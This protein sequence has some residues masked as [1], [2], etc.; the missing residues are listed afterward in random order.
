MSDWS[1]RY[2]PT[3]LQGHNF[4][5]KTGSTNVTG[6]DFMLRFMSTCPQLVV[7]MGGVQ[8]PCL[9]DIGSMV[10][11]ITESCFGSNF[12]SWGQEKLRSVTALSCKQPFNSLYR[13][14][15][16]RRGA[17]CASSFRMRHAG[18]P[19]SSW[20]CVCTNSWVVWHEHPEPL[21]PGALWPTWHSLFFIY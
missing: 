19:R 10:S 4:G 17:L 8:V 12:G 18:G 9:V 13:L 14:F 7:S 2:T 11:T 20:W 1:R 3:E 15:G 5:K 21:L 6:S 16:I